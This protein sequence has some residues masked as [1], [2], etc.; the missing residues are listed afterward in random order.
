MP[1]TDELDID[2]IFSGKKK[3]PL[4]GEINS[5]DNYPRLDIMGLARKKRKKT[6]VRRRTVKRHCKRK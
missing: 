1:I 4:E 3:V 6:T 2:N 5:T